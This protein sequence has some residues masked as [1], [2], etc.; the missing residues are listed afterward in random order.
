MGFLI[1]VAAC[2]GGL[3]LYYSSVVGVRTPAAPEPFPAPQLQRAPLSDLEK[4]QHKEDS[5]ARVAWVDKNQG[6][7]DISIE[8]AMQIVASKGSAAFGSLDDLN[9]APPAPKGKNE[10]AKAA[11]QNAPNEAQR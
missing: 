10:T 5:T 6:I 3:F 1:F 7:V 8:R 2:I 4:L 11:Q 9:K